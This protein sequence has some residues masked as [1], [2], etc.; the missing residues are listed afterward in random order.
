MRQ[1]ND[2]GVTNGFDL[3]D[4]FSKTAAQRWKMIEHIYLTTGFEHDSEVVV[5]YSSV[6]DIKLYQ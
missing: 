2:P 1:L 6:G 5:S 3:C 4:R